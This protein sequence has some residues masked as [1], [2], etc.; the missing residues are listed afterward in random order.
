MDGQTIAPFACHPEE[1]PWAFGPP[2][3]M[4]FPLSSSPRGRPWRAPTTAGWGDFQESPDLIGATRSDGPI[5]IGPEIGPR[6]ARNDNPKQ[7]F[8]QTLKPRPS[9][10]SARRRGL[11]SAGTSALPRPPYRYRRQATT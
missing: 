5:P 3:G 2:E 8:T 11:S 4:K 1:L 7:I 9:R 6:F 10:H